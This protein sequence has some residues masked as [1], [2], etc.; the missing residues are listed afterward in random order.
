M[1]LTAYMG[2]TFSPIHLGHLRA[3]WEVVTE[4]GADKCYL[5]PNWLPVHREPPHVTPEH[6]ARMVELAI[7]NCNNLALDDSEI[8]RGEPSYTIDTMRA[9]RASQPDAPLAFVVGQDAF[10]Q[11]NSWKEWEN[12]PEVCHL[13]VVSR[14]GH[15]ANY[16]DSIA[17][18][19]A[20]R[21]IDSP[22]DLAASP[23]GGIYFHEMTALDISSTRIR[24]LVEMGVEPRFLV[25]SSVWDYIRD[26][27]LFFTNHA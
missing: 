19:V 11:F 8:K 25:P 1:A 23:A 14:P 17:S 6:R 21:K 5:T 18:F 9:H 12:L 27:R 4:L 2:G 26:K 20:K 3:A 7:Q 13:I 10:C 22:K 24:T 15:S 16:C